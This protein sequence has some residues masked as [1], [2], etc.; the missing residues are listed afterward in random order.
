M[1]KYLD[2]NARIRLTNVLTNKDMFDLASEIV[3]EFESLKA[4]D[5]TIIVHIMKV[6]RQ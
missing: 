3:E 4:A 5:V 2:P 1:T 6:G